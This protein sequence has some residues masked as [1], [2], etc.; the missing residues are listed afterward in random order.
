MAV[1]RKLDAEEILELE[2][3]IDRLRQIILQV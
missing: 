1:A 3:R 2:G